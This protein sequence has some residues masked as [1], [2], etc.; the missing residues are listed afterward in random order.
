MKFYEKCADRNMG[1]PKFTR[2]LGKDQTRKRQK[3]KH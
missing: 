1:M 2:H 3:S